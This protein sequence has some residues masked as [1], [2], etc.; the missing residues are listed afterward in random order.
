MWY[1]V[2]CGDPWER[3]KKTRLKRLSVLQAC[4][5]LVKRNMLGRAPTQI[6]KQICLKTGKNLGNDQTGW[7]N[8]KKSGNDQ[9]G[10]KIGG[11]TRQAE[12]STKPIPRSLRYR[13]AGLK[14]NFDH[15]TAFGFCYFEKS[16]ERPDIHWKYCSAFVL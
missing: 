2:F 15:F 13:Y 6:C 3:S 7:K 10:W 1:V 5:S 12:K 11:T 16:L 14:I 9:T 8:G 4:V